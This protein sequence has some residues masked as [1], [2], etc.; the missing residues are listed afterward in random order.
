MR[1]CSKWVTAN[2]TL[3]TP[4]TVEESRVSPGS[5]PPSVLSTIHRHSPGDITSYQPSHWLS[6]GS[7]DTQERPVCVGESVPLL[8]RERFCCVWTKHSPWL[9]RW[10]EREI[11]YFLLRVCVCLR[12]LDSCN[13]RILV[14]FLSLITR[15]DHQA[16]LQSKIT[17]FNNTP[18][19]VMITFRLRFYESTRDCMMFSICSEEDC[20]TG[21]SLNCRTLHNQQLVTIY[22]YV[23][24][25]M[26]GNKLLQREPAAQPAPGVKTTTC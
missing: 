11:W 21:R 20:L 22:I 24:S 10:K 4:P 9:V 16:K 1:L 3:L 8:E 14:P 6:L 5:M 26:W 12:S 18:N 17:E 25:V 23:M 2:N 7:Q 15:E 13:V 19:H